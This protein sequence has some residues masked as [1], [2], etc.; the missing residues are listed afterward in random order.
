MTS[1]FAGLAFALK[2]GSRNFTAT[3]STR[4][5]NMVNIYI[6][7]AMVW[8]GWLVFNGGSANTG[9]VRGVY[10][11]TN[12]ILSSSIGGIVW[13]VK[14]YLVSGRWSTLGIVS[15]ILAGLVGVTP[16]S[17]YVA[18]WGAVIIGMITSLSCNYACSIKLYIGVDDALDAFAV[19][20]KDIAFDYRNWW[21]CGNYLD[22]NLFY[23]LDH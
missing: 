12:T 14:D 20:G 13:S 9:S 7:T 16:A 4:P 3:E 19:H 23:L 1:G 8:F 2:L 15:G 6:G 17:G 22:W 18:P 11:F 5:H 10:A 21:I